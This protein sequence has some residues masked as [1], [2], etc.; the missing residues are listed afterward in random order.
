MRLTP[1]GYKRYTPSPR[2]DGD[3]VQTSHFFKI[4]FCTWH[5]W[6]IRLPEAIYKFSE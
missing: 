4:E 2:A 1:E 3:K 6:E 5:L